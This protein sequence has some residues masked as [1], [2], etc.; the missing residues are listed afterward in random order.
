MSTPNWIQKRELA[1]RGKAQKLYTFPEGTTLVKF[2]FSVEPV[3]KKIDGAMKTL[4]TATISGEK[5]TF[6]VS[7]TL[8]RMLIDCFKQNV[9]DIEVTRTGLTIDDTVY[10]VMAHKK[11]KA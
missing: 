7:K 2:D 9:A 8:E 11:S 10:A 3:E 6:A 5:Q 1:L 4:Y